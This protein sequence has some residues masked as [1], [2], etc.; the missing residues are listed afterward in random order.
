LGQE[1]NE[2]VFLI[3]TPSIMHGRL[4]GAHSTIFKH[5]LVLIIIKQLPLGAKSFSCFIL[6]TIVHYESNKIATP[7]DE[8]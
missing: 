4:V 7:K 3:S 8:R 6:G 1:Y 2:T 5:N